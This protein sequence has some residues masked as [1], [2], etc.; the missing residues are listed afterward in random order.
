MQVQ[1]RVR[2]FFPYHKELSQV[3]VKIV[4]RDRTVVPEAMKEEV[5]QR[6]HD[7]HLR[8]R[9]CLEQMCK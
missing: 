9:K 6:I 3:D 1:E 5:V 8:V 2:I 7:S 4:Y